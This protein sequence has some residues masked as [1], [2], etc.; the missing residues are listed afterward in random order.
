[1]AIF[2]NRTPIRFPDDLPPLTGLVTA[3]ER[4]EHALPGGHGHLRDRRDEGPGEGLRREDLQDAPHGGEPRRLL[5]R[6]AL[7]FGVPA[8]EASSGHRR[9]YH[10]HYSSTMP[11]NID[12]SALPCRTFKLERPCAACPTA[13][14]CSTCR[15]L[16]TGSSGMARA[17]CAVTI[18]RAAA[19]APSW[20]C[21]LVHQPPAGDA[22]SSHSAA[23]A[24]S[25]RE[26]QCAPVASLSQSV[27]D[28]R[29]LPD[30]H[31][32]CLRY[33]RSASFRLLRR[34]IDT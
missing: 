9:S 27:E 29:E 16:M 31:M 8:G 7:L 17:R 24:F 3:D 28:Q 21:P 4:Q 14:T 1:M 20:S 26:S 22:S 25:S 11:P 6:E 12:A 5:G 15:A 13:G 34:Q 2:T 10:C 18:C 23:A 30:R 32:A 33:C 19:G